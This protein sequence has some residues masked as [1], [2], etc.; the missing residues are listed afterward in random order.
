MAGIIGILAIFIAA[1]LFVKVRF[2][3]GYES[4]AQKKKLSRI[5]AELARRGADEATLKAKAMNANYSH[6]P[7][8]EE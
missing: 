5:Q 8:E 4:E 3:S 2:Q 6:T 7:K 1:S